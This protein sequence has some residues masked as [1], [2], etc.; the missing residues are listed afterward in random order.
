MH[1]AG[2]TEVAPPP[3]APSA[4][5]SDELACRPRLTSP[6]RPRQSTNQAS[7]DVWRHLPSLDLELHASSPQTAKPMY[8][9]AFLHLTGSEPCRHLVL[10]ADLELLLYL[11]LWV[12]LCGC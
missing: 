5:A 2:C 9:F 1:A 12:D 8:V 7:H 10:Q 4:A 3:S 6:L 11:N